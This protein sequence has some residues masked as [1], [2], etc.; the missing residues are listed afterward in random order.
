MRVSPSNRTLPI[1]TGTVLQTGE[2]KKKQHTSPCH[3]GADPDFDATLIFWTCKTL[4]I[5]AIG[6][7]L[8]PEL[9]RMMPRDIQRPWKGFYGWFSPFQGIF[10]VF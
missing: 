10:L 2:R 9:G 5:G 6:M 4:N 7:V 1:H 8:S 3:D